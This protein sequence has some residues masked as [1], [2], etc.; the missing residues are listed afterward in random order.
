MIFEID[1]LA[2]PDESDD[3]GELLE[4]VLLA[5]FIDPSRLDQ[6]TGIEW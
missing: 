1:D 3:H 2:I 6:A 5:V 4:T